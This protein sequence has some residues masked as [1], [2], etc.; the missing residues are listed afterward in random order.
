MNYTL[1][2]LPHLI[3]ITEV[4]FKIKR[5]GELKVNSN[6]QRTHGDA[7]FRGRI[8]SIWG[9]F[10]SSLHHMAHAVS[11]VVLYFNILN[12]NRVLNLR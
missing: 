9:F 10:S 4:S 5:R 1:S 7:F 11:C 3:L 8:V 12:L 2:F 6:L